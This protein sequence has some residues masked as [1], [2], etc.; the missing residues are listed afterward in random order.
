MI[1]RDLLYELDHQHESTERIG[2]TLDSRVQTRER[3]MAPTVI[4]EGAGGVPSREGFV[5]LE[6]LRNSK[7]CQTVHRVLGHRHVVGL[8]RGDARLADVDDF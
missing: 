7:R 3:L 8:A 1:E 4:V 2:D 5:R 6:K